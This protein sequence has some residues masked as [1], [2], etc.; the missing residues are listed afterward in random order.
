MK[1]SKFKKILKRLLF[2]LPIAAII[3]LGVIAIINRSYISDQYGTEY[4][5]ESGEQGILTLYYNGAEGYPDSDT[6]AYE[7]YQDIKLPTLEKEGYKFIGWSN[8]GAFTEKSIILNSKESSVIAL[9]TKN[10]SE[11][12][13]PIAI[14]TDENNYDEFDTGE[15]PSVSYSN[16]YLYVEGGYELHTYSQENFNGTENVYVYSSLSKGNFNMQN[17]EIK[18]MK[19]VPINSDTVAKGELDDNKKAELL[20]AFAPRIW[21]SEGEEYF[22]ASVEDAADNMTRVMTDRITDI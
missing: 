17:D 2:I 6:I 7:A 16:F 18:S 1:K 4:M 15:Y 13:K 9:F 22:A 21:W 8:Y 12:N 14:Y 19:I 20:T 3:A 10:F 11:I 5:L